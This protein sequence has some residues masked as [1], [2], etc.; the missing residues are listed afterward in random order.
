MPSFISNHDLAEPATGLS[1]EQLASLAGTYDTVATP[2]WICD[3]RDR[4]LYRNPPARGVPVEARPEL[5]FDIL[6]HRSRVVARLATT[7]N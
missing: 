4:C 6:D 5:T 7:R 1:A 2:V 3:L